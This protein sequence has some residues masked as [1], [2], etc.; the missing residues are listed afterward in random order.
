MEEWD[1][2]AWTCF[3][4]PR[5]TKKRFKLEDFHPFRGRTQAVNIFKLNKRIDELGKNLPETLSKEEIE[6]MWE[7]RKEKWRKDAGKR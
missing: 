3:F 1:K 6:K 4:I 2:V 7:K 5:F